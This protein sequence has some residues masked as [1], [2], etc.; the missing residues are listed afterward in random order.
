[1]VIDFGTVKQGELLDGN[2]KYYNH[3][4]TGFI[5]ENIQVSCGCIVAEYSKDTLAPGDSAS[6]SIIFDTAG[7]SKLHTKTIAVYSSH[8]LFE[9]TMKANIEK[10]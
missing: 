10:D 5:I 9:L 8:G 6:V 7:K 3:S 4:N 2:F 1:M